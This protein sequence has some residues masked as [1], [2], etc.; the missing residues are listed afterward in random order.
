VHK[1]TTGNNLRGSQPCVTMNNGPIR[2]KAYAKLNLTLEIR[3]Q[4]PD[5]YHEIRSVVQTISLADEISVQPST[6]TGTRLRVQGYPVPGGDDNLVMAALR[7]ASTRL[8][9]SR[10]LEIRLTKRIPPGRGLGGGSSDAAAILRALGCLYDWELDRD[11][12]HAVAAETGSDVPLFLRGGLML[13]SG[14][15]EKV[16]RSSPPYP[17]YRLAL[18]WPEL[19]VPTGLAYSLLEPADYSEGLQTERLWEYLQEGQIPDPAGLTNCFERIVFLRW[20]PI[21]DLHARMSELAGVPARMTG[22][23]SAVFAI[24]PRA[25]DAVAQ[26]RAEGYEAFVAHPVEIGQE[27]SCGR[28]VVGDN[29]C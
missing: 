20:P 21:A 19:E 13:V 15:G 22:S 2:I 23:G 25:E 6:T 8:G 9:I 7:L 16:E 10:D 29:G 11:V 17:D 5:G 28:S 1:R 4:R 27:L 18:A 24:T 26:L 14:R 3:G 12:L